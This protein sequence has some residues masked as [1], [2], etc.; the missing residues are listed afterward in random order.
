MPSYYLKKYF[1]R[2][3]FSH[4]RLIFFLKLLCSDFHFDLKRIISFYVSQTIV[5]FPGFHRFKKPGKFKFFS[6]YQKSL[7]KSWSGIHLVNFIRFLSTKNRGR[8]LRD[9][10]WP[11]VTGKETNRKV[12]KDLTQISQSSVLQTNNF[13]H[14]PPSVCSLR[15]NYLENCSFELPE[16]NSKL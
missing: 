15:L 3:A 8:L 9:I 5:N 7:L 10:T 14:S 11:E 2:P 12:R 4:V 1:C 13:A 16:L 6:N